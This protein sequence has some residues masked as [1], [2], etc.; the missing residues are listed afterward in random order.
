MSLETKLFPDIP[1]LIEASVFS[2]IRG[3]FATV[4]EGG[5]I[6]PDNCHF[7]FNRYTATLRGLHYQ[8]KPHAQGKLVY[9]VSGEIYDVAVDLRSKSANT[10]RW[11]S[12]RLAGMSSKALWIPPGFAHGFLTLAPNTVVAY[13]ISGAYVPDASAGIR[14]NDPELNITWPIVPEVLSERDRQLPCLSEAAEC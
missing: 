4:W 1:E 10:C 12:F 3:V 8:K 5:G 11:N 14:W 9:C 6:R 13:L 7:S 2:D